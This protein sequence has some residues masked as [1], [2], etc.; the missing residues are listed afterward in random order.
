ML[1]ITQIKIEC[2]HGGKSGIAALENKIKKILRLNSGDKLDFR[3]TK[4]SVDCRKK[5]L[6]FDVYN[7]AVKLPDSLEKKLLARK[8]PGCSLYSEKKYVF[9]V[10]GS[11]SLTERPVII[12]FG[13][14]GI[15]AALMLAYNGYRPLVLERGRCM[16]KRTEDVE[17]FWSGSMLNENSNIQFGEGGAGT[18]S[19][20]KLNT[21]VN[22]REGRDRAVLEQFV[23]AGAPKEILYEGKPHIGTDILRNVIS[24][25]RQRIEKSGG[26]I[27]FGSTVTSLTEENG[28]ITGVVV[29]GDEQIRASVVILAP[30]HS[31][32][33]TF[34]ELYREGVCLEQKDF[35]VG[36]RVLHPQ[37]LIDHD[38]YGTVNED[39]RRAKHL[40]PASYKLAAKNASGRGV[41]SFCMCPGGYVVNASSERNML[42]VNGMSYY[43][44]GSAQAN[45]A[46]VMTISAKDYG[47]SAPLD[48][49]RFQRELEKKC[50]AIGEGD[51]PVE[52]FND[53]EAGKEEPSD[54]PDDLCIKGAY[55]KADLS[56]LLPADLTVDFIEGMHLFDRKIKGFAGSEAFV[57]GLES[58]TSSPVRI[59][60]DNDFVASI[61]GLYPCGEGAGYAG[62][63]MSAA[64][65]GIKTAEA[66]AA[67]FRP[68]ANKE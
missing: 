59:T 26:E 22:D 55:K 45:S 25:L 49:M 19:D 11:E 64:M 57:A 27:R 29:N 68:F 52:R 34:E 46:I 40:T 47:G 61:K 8:I 66:V 35:A 15:F 10:N 31:A 23:S 12:G 32:R 16:A 4:H 44:R 30:G 53:M 54:L 13:P 37:S 42:A 51:V 9:P 1:S 21:L 38:Q 33:D 43:G 14:A 7:V 39:D 60:R 62:G 56:G 18:F 67:K 3:I 65:D 41:Y 2:G 50:F 58:R 24:E 6:L 28:N 17:K 20:G 36:F 63:I 48:G 5:P